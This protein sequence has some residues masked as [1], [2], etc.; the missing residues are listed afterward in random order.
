LF[1][2]GECGCGTCFDD[3]TSDSTQGIKIETSVVQSDVRGVSF[4]GA[5]CTQICKHKVSDVKG[6]FIEKNI[7]S[8]IYYIEDLTLCWPPLNNPPKIS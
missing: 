1:K 2:K 7:M 4:S 3:R 5:E 8:D 6:M